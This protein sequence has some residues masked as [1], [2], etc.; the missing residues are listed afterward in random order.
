MEPFDKLKHQVQDSIVEEISALEKVVRAF[1][2]VVPE[3][4]HT[5]L[6]V[7]KVRTTFKTVEDLVLA[8][9]HSRQTLVRQRVRNPYYLIYYQ[10]KEEQ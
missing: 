8:E 7:L 4:R 9:K 3:Y 1:V 2:D 10:R 6:D 5:S